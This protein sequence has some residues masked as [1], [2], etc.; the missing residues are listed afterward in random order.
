MATLAGGSLAAMMQRM[1]SRG[2]DAGGAFSQDRVAFG[3]RRLS[4]IDLAAASQQPMI[5]PELG[6]AIVFNGCIYNFRELRSELSAK[7]YRFFS[8][9]DTEVILK[10]YKEWGPRCVERFYGMFAF[11]IWERDSGRVVLARDR[12]GIKPLY[13]AEAAGPF[14][15]RF[16]AA[17]VA[18]RR[19]RRYRDRSRG[20]ASLSELARRG[21]GADDDHQG[22]AQA[23]AG[24][25]LHDR[26]DGRRREETYWRLEVGPRAGGSRH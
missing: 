16:D 18:R 20:A 14:P 21:A 6:L 9:G 2:P 1:W 8:Q 11:A 15:L 23:R 3:H 12:L 24:H 26:A 5:D 22:R 4:I 7:G 25:D 13:Y 10:A 19:R 17:R